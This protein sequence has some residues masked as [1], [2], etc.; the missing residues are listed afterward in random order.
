MLMNFST[1][2]RAQ[3]TLIGFILLFGILVISLSLYQAQ[4]IP[5]QNAEVEFNHYQEVQDDMVN[6][7]AEISTIGSSPKSGQIVVP[8][9]TGTRYP[10]RIGINPPPVAGTIES[11]DSGTMFINGSSNGITDICGSNTTSGIR[12]E[13]GYHVLQQSSITYENGILYLKDNQEDYV[14]LE[15]QTLVDNS[16]RNIN[17][18]RLNGTFRNR[19]SVRSIPIELTGTKTYG[20]VELS[21]NNESGIT[22]PSNLPASQ[23]NSNILPSGITAT[24][25]GSSVDLS[26]FGERSYTIKCHTVGLGQ[27]PV[28]EFKYKKSY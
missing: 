3:A 6:L 17:L 19:G 20:E 8:V 14:I 13:S 26:G 18:Y 15:Q 4:I 10:Q 22:L 27:R 7:Y 24:Q 25:N 9:T 5:N 16:S 23:W 12:Y 21:V 2:N 28:T 1:S 11:T